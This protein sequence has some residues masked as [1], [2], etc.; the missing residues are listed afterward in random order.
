MYKELIN[1]INKLTDEKINE[2]AIEIYTYQK[3]GIFPKECFMREMVDTFE[4]S[5]KDVKHILFSEMSKRYKIIVLLL[6]EN[7]INDFIVN[8]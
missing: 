6:L 7:R 1:V 8:M 3:T 2:I 4:I 5:I